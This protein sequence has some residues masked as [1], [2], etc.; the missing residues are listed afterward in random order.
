MSRA[1][2]ELAQ[3]EKER[4]G[5]LAERERRATKRTVGQWDTRLAMTSS[6]SHVEV[7]PKVFSG[8]Q[9]VRGL[10]ARRRRGRPLDHIASTHRGRLF[11]NFLFCTVKH[12][13]S[14]D[15]ILDT[16][17][18][19]SGRRLLLSA[20]G[21]GKFW[22]LLENDLFRAPSSERPVSFRCVASMYNHP[23]FWWVLFSYRIYLIV[24]RLC[25]EKC[26][27]DWNQSEEIEKSVGFAMWRKPEVQWSLSREV[28]LFDK[29]SNRTD[30]SVHAIADLLEGLVDH[31]RDFSFFGSQGRDYSLTG[32][33]PVGC[34]RTQLEQH[35]SSLNFAYL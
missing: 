15:C 6:L 31:R 16:R 35:L 4:K 12:K 13:L 24:S 8:Y 11:Y 7:S 22:S 1:R 28:W 14:Q 5:T 27:I 25:L 26:Q 10:P 34:P 18:D 17:K 32:I 9:F 23:T 21:T 30:R 33:I 2:E 29:R 3:K 20:M 19:W